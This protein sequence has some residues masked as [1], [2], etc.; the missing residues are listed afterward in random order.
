MLLVT[1]WGFT[2]R[3]LW[4]RYAALLNQPMAEDSL[5]NLDLLLSGRCWLSDD[6]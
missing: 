4:L 1:Y 5:R 3:Q 6:F 2:G